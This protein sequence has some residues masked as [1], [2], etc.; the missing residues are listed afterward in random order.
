MPKSPQQG[1]ICDRQNRPDTVP[2][3]PS[4]GFLENANRVGN[5]GVTI[6]PEFYLPSEAS[7]LARARQWLKIA[8]G[9]GI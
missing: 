5:G 6:Q 8:R 1:G 2:D 4:H 9:E 3:K 7:R